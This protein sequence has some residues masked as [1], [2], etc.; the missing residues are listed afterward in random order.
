[1]DGEKKLKRIWDN[2]KVVGEAQK[3]ERLK[4]VIATG[5]RDGYRCVI[6]REFYLRKADNTWR[7]GR[8]GIIIPLISPLKGM[9]NEDGTP[10]TVLP[11]NQMLAALPAAY[12]E[13]RTMELFDKENEVWA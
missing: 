10:Q 9:F 7:P 1:M 4:F 8:D 2:Y 11:F 3:N 6:I 5:T 12:E 13:A